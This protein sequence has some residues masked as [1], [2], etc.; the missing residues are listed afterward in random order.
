M[1]MFSGYMPHVCGSGSIFEPFDE[2]WLY[3]PTNDSWVM[4]SKGPLTCDVCTE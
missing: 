2:C 3:S 4:T 1:P